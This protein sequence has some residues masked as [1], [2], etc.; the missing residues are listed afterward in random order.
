MAFDL[1]HYLNDQIKL[2]KPFL[3]NQYP[4]YQRDHLLQEHSAL[5]LGKLVSLWRSN[6]QEQFKKLTENK[7][8][9]S[10]E[11][12]NNLVKPALENSSLDKEELKSILH[13]ILSLHLSELRQLEQTGQFGAIGLRDLLI[14]QIEYL[15]AEAD[16]W[17]WSANTLIELKG[18]KITYLEDISLEQSNTE[19]Y[20]MVQQSHTHE[21]KTEDSAIAPCWAKILE[22][23]VALVI[24]WILFNALCNIFA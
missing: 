1:V 17:V 22:P 2:Q 4:E 15:A 5:I 6:H 19:S 14:G 20:Q 8:Q 3:L 13:E 18:S 9:Y 11:I 24:L 10:N 21:E 7:E 23:I 12:L 16:D